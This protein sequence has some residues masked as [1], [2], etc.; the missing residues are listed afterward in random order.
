M[1]AMCILTV[2]SA[3]YNYYSE[4]SDDMENTIFPNK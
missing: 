2:T 1:Y 3:T 4:F